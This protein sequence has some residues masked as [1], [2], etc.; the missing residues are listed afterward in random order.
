MTISN[1]LDVPLPTFGAMSKATVWRDYRDLRVEQCAA[2]V[3]A[4]AETQRAQIGN[5]RV[6]LPSRGHLD[7]PEV[8]VERWPASGRS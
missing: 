1:P 6:C 4:D 7:R 2:A 3:I 8:A 5:D